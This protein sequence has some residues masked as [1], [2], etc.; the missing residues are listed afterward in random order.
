MLDAVIAAV[1][2]V[3]QQEIMPRYQHVSRQIKVD[4][5]SVTEADF[6]TQAMLFKALQTQRGQ[7]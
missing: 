5:S 7:V 2:S 3:A 4:G 1:R 6:A